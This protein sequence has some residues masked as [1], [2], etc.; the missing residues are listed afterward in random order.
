MSTL[1]ED[2]LLKTAQQAIALARDLSALE[3]VRVD[4]LGRKSPLTQAIKA[5]AQCSPEERPRLGKTLNQLKNKLV[6]AI[7][8]QE[9]AFSKAALALKLKSEAIDVTL[10]GR[11]PILGALHPITQVRLRLEK[12]FAF[13]GF[14]VVSGPEVENPYYNFEA[15]NIP[16]HHPARTMHDTFYLEGGGFIKNA[17]IF[18]SNSRDGE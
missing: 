13:M 4:T 6:S 3:Q 7:D 8:S 16:A 9:A 1:D 17:Y 5:I 11:G 2:L 18:G 10:P 14:E 15:L 12:I